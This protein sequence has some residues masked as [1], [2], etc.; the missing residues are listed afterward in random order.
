MPIYEY[1]CLNCGRKVSIFW[2]SLSAVNEAEARCEYCGSRKL[3]RLVSR[4]RVMR[5]GSTSSEDGLSDDLLNELEGIDENN[6]RALGRLMRRMA[7]ETGEDMGPEFE[8]IVSRLERGEDPERI[9]KELGDLFGEEG[10][11]DDEFAP[12]ASAEGATAGDAETSAKDNTE[13]KSTTRRTVAMG[14]ARK[15]SPS[16]KAKRTSQSSRKSSRSRKARA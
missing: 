2:R 4:V 11:E 1:R 6:P 8:E 7:E 14:R 15:R 16:S 12:S 5:H 9:E 13:S 3:K 10:M